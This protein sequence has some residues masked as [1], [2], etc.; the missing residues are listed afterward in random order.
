MFHLRHIPLAIPPRRIG[1]FK[2][3]PAHTVSRRVRIL[4]SRR[5]DINL[6][7]RTD[8][9]PILLRSLVDLARDRFGR[10]GRGI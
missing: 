8:E 5:A 1:R 2:L 7:P 4:G 10:E 9:R 6:G 3:C